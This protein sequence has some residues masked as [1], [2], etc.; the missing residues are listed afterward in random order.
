MRAVL[1]KDN[2]ALGLPLQGM[3]QATYG[4]PGL[5]SLT[6]INKDENREAA[7]DVLAYLSSAESQKALNAAATATCRPVPTSR[8]RA[9]DPTSRS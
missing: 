4:N 8:R 9:P 3:V 6:S 5:L 2:V 1:G 7:Y